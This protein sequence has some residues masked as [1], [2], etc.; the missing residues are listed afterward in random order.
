MTYVHCVSFAVPRPVL[1]LA[2][3]LQFMY[4]SWDQSPKHTFPE[5]R[6][7]LHAVMPTRRSNP[8]GHM[9][10][11]ASSKG[12]VHILPIPWWIAAPLLII[13]FPIIKY[14]GVEGVC[15]YDDQEQ[16]WFEAMKAE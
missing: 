3:Y 1:R 9:S 6:A 12:Y 13:L 15:T 7:Q 10:Q 14:D 5:E 8:K 4:T 16:I 2:I 11:P